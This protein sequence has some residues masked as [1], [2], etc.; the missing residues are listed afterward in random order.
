MTEKDNLF[1]Q[2]IRFLAN[3]N[4]YFMELV[5]IAKEMAGRKMPVMV[6]SSDA[7]LR[8]F[9]SEV[10]AFCKCKTLSLFEYFAASGDS[11]LIQKIKELKPGSVL[12]LDRIEK[13]SIDFQDEILGLIESGF[14]DSADIL[15]LAGFD[16]KSVS[17]E[18]LVEEGKFSAKLAY[19]LGLLKVN[20]LNLN[21]IK[22]GAVTLA[23]VILNDASLCSGKQIKGFS[24]PAIAA[25]ENHFWKNGVFELRAAVE[26]AVS[27]SET[28]YIPAEALPFVSGTADNTEEAAFQS[29]GDDKTMKAALDSFKRFYVK[30]I[31]E[32][33]G[34]NQT[35]AAKVLGLQR[36]YVS[37]LISELNIR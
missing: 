20:V 3:K 21:E 31:L 6:N 34:N 1:L 24:E 17:V 28:D 30:K 5:G 37:R 33:N 18:E 7:F 16:A 32:E 2:K 19:R 10:T 9:F 13:L 26:Y 22:G 12:F 15:F 35:Q 27:V 23:W 14:F 29:L 36:T 11:N 4:P 8:N 25:I